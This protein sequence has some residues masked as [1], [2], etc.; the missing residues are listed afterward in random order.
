[1]TDQKRGNPTKL[2]DIIEKLD[3]Y[4]Y[5]DKGEKTGTNIRNAYEKIL[6]SI[7]LEEAHNKVDFDET[8][9]VIIMFTDGIYNSGGNPKGIVGQIREKVI[10]DKKDREKYLDLYA[11]GVGE[12][13]EKEKMDEWV[14]KRD[15][16][17]KYFF[18]LPN[19]EEVEETLDK[20]LDEGTSMA[21]CGLYKS[22]SDSELK[23]S[24]RLTYPWLIKIVITYNGNTANC[25]GSL[26][27]PRFIL[28]AAHCFRFDDVN[29]QIKLEALNSKDIQIPGVEKFYLHEKFNTT[30]KQDKGITEFYEY[31]VALIQLTEGVKISPDLR[32]I[33]VPCTEEAHAALQLPASEA[34]CAKH[35]E[36]LLDSD[37]MNAHF[38]THDALTS[39]KPKQ[40]VLIKQNQ[41][42]DDCI[43]QTTKILN[44]EKEKAEE[45]FTDK[46]L[47]T[48]G[49][50]PNFI[51][52]ISCKGDSGGPLVVEKNRLFQ[53]GIISWGLK[54]ICEDEMEKVDGRDFHIHLFDPEVQNFLQKYLGDEEI[55][56]PLNFFSEAVIEHFKSIFAHHG[57]PEVVRSDNGPQF[58]SE[59]F[60]AFARGWGF[61]HVTSSPHFP[62]SNW[63]AERAVRTIKNLLKKSADPYL[64]LMAYRVAP[65]TNGYSPAELLM[66]RKLRMR[67]TG[68][69]IHNAYE[70]ILESISLEE[71]HNKVDFDETQHVIIMFT[72]G[73]Y[74]SGGNPKGIVGQIREKVIRDKKDREK[75]LDLYAFGVGEDIEKEKMDEWV[76]KRDT[77]EKYFFILPNMEEVEETLDKMLDEGTSMALCGLYKSY[78][79]PGLKSSM[80]LTYPWL[81]KIVITYNGNTANC[82]GSLVTPRF[83]LT[84]AHCFRFDD[85]NDQI[86]LEALNSKDIQI[87]GVERFYLHK[88][89][90]ITQKRDKGITEFYD[91]DVA[92]IQLTE[93]VKIS[94]DLR[95][96]CVPCTQEAHA[97]LQLPASEASCAKH[98]EMLLDSELVN[99][100]F[101]TH[102][103]LTSQNPKQQVIIK[104]NQRRD[105]CIEQTTKILNV[106]KE[107]AE[108][109]FTDK[110]LCT[111]GETPNFIDDISCKGDSG[112][113]LVVE[114]NRLFQ[115]GIISWGLKDICETEMEKVDGRDF[116]IH[117]FD[118]EVQTFLKK[119]LGD[120]D[121]DTPLNFF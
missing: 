19:M 78:S 9:H 43:E 120:E 52:D 85:V 57:I 3:K 62:Q 16:N 37:L 65:L 72:D 22:Y 55:D 68:T 96:I 21:L 84:A 51:D 73:I 53:V 33:C 103:A 50:T 1:M 118:P 97:A 102:D 26:V 18:I 112:G 14:S 64:A 61:D 94:P 34:S 6:E 56:T 27:T 95:T 119:Y 28:T 113:P 54:D 75:Y 93:G 30:K 11:F 17:E 86:Q 41:W 105:D 109:M 69:N 76:S 47:C 89:F 10:R 80:R 2:K 71:A 35:R 100:H 107:I 31:D 7:S 4:K 24:M 58:A 114:K 39:K 25:I 15:T 77:N 106:E 49:E 32:T 82:I 79:E 98:R 23:S 46:F 42:R 81:I 45:M 121:I 59:G 99:A 44:V 66:G 92:L 88:Q 13:I 91:Y 115:V 12:D 87:P 67:K 111:G 116:H 90:N 38:I 70:K 83:I 60:R 48:G 117:L 20:M 101:I 108:E 36:M 8:Q 29:D 110:F 63:E 74:N 104:Q 40:Q 5:S